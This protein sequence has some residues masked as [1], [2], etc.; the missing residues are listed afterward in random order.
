MV[1]M[2]TDLVLAKV[3]LLDLLLIDLGSIILPKSIISSCPFYVLLLQESSSD[4]F[5]C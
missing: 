4:P 1:S 5:G 2:L 3:V